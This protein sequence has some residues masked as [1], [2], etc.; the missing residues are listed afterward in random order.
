MFECDTV[1]TRTKTKT[2]EGDYQGDSR[3]ASHVKTTRAT[4][5]F[6]KTRTLKEQREYLPAFACRE[7]LLRAIRDNQGMHVRS[8]L[9]ISVNQFDLLLQWSLSWA[10][11]VLEKPH[12]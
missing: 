8:H 2:S 10:R 4:S 11:L 7:D 1:E 9:M 5:T 3:F 12:N 6:A